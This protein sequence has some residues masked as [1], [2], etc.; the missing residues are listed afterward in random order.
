MSYSQNN[1]SRKYNEIIHCNV[2]PDPETVLIGLAR[3]AVPD[4]YES[5]DLR[6]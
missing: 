2:L 4:L 3:V 6:V 1:I 5:R